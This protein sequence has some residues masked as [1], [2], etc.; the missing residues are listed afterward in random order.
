[1]WRYLHEHR[2]LG[3]GAISTEVVP[4]V[5]YVAGIQRVAVAARD[6]TAARKFAEKW[7]FMR[8]YGSYEELV[9]DPEVEVI[10]IGTPNSLHYEHMMLCLRHGKGVICEKAFC[11]NAHQAQEV[12]SYAREHGLFVAEAVWTRYM[13][14]RAAIAQILASGM[15]GRPYMLTANLFYPLSGVARVTDPKLGGGAL[16]D[17][18]VYPLNFALMCFGTEIERVESSVQLYPTGVDAMENITLHYCDGRMAA[19]TAGIFSRSDRKG[20]IHGELGYLVVENINNPRS[21]SVYHHR[22]AGGFVMQDELVQHLDFPQPVNGYEYEFEEICG[23]YDRGETQAV[24][25]PWDETLRVMR[26][27]D[28]LRAPWGV[29]YP[30]DSQS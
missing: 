19:L 16:L 13:P 24:S 7:G 18:G 3:A 27:F 6:L 17:V 28:E 4:A 20:I 29:R 9:Q 1:M 15:I 5:Q 26:L 2:F 30:Q 25:M 14:S 23:C 10:Y 8:A 12:L 22:S 11:L 21:V